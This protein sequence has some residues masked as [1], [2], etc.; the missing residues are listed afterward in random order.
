MRFHITMNM[1]SR[2]GNFVHNIIGEH[3]AKS[4]TEFLSVLADNPFVV[5]KEI[6]FDE[7]SREM[8]PV[9]D[10]AINPYWIGKIKVYR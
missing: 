8:Y 6:Y 1:P 7:V 3:S 10:L 9:G 5:V 2:A 4:L